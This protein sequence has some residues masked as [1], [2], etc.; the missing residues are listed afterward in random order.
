MH[1]RRNYD[2]EFVV[3]QTAGSR[4]FDQDSEPKETPETRRVLAKITVKGILPREQLN[5]L[6]LGT[7]RTDNVW[8]D[9][10]L[11]CDFS[12]QH[13]SCSIPTNFMQKLRCN[14]SISGR[15]CLLDDIWPLSRIPATKHDASPFPTI[16]ELLGMRTHKVVH[17]RSRY[18]PLTGATM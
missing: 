1:D 8:T 11:H 3:V 5:G 15:L 18:S 9:N 4:A 10:M 13:P 12:L 14:Q 16:A 6:H 7:L 17:S 2:Y